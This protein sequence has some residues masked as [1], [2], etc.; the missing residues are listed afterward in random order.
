M[1]KPEKKL[2]QRLYRYDR[3]Q[4]YLRKRSELDEVLEEVFDKLTLMT[5]YD[6]MNKGL[7]KEFYG[8]VSAGKESRIYLARDRDLNYLAVKIYL[9]TSAEFKKNRVMYISGDPRFKR[10]PS[11]F[12][13]FI[14]LWAKREFS[15]LEAAYN[16]GVS[17]PKPLFVRNN[18]LGMSF[19]GEDGR[20]YPTLAEVKLTREEL[21]EIY[22]Q[23]INAVK[24][25]YNEAKLV[26]GDLSEYNIFKLPNNS[27]AFIDLSQA[28]HVKQPQADQLLL[29]DL[30]NVI[31]F[32][33]K[34]GLEVGE[35]ESLFEE[36]TGRLPKYSLSED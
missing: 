33:K 21:E 22:P 5:L 9:V 6:L 4:R 12:R 27:I 20:R 35:L 17:V 25:M 11:D 24:K 36:I 23:V 2:Q 30:K 1:S 14:Y 16:V 8:V 13:N 19:L 10:I 3:E 26:H 34:N 7:I 29:R 15:N 32:F 31:R 18:I 28:V